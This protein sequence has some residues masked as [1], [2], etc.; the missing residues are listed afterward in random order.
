MAKIVKCQKCRNL[1]AIAGEECMCC[2]YLIPEELENFVDEGSTETELEC[3]FGDF[4]SE[5]LICH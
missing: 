5:Y 4:F 3:L 2:G 1:T